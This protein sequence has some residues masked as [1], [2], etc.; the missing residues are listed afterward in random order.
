LKKG[1]E[2]QGKEN[3]Q[4][5]KCREKMEGACGNGAHNDGVK[6]TLAREWRL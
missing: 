3:K 2:I 4:E 5:S 1:K 6:H